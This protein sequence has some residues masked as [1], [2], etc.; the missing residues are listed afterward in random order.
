MSL[1]DGRMLPIYV[2]LLLLE[3]EEGFPLRVEM[4]RSIGLLVLRAREFGTLLNH[5]DF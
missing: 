5:W 4:V 2:L 1:G 3:E